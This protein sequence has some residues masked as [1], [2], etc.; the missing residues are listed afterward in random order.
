LH[1][2]QR[3][4][5]ANEI[6]DESNDARSKSKKSSDVDK[7]ASIVEEKSEGQPGCGGLFVHESHTC[8][9]QTSCTE[10]M[11]WIWRISSKNFSTKAASIKAALLELVFNITFAHWKI[12]PMNVCD[13]LFRIG[14]SIV[15]FN[16]EGPQ[17]EL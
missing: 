4:I 5:D 10:V 8:D 13:E 14:R 9:T 1:P 2:E 17:G 12:N 16:G 11:V 15:A 6:A 3:L 7:L